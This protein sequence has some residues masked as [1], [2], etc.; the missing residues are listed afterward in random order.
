MR[1][2]VDDIIMTGQ[3][4]RN[5]EIEEKLSYRVWISKLGTDAI[6]LEHGS[7]KIK[8]WIGVSQWKYILNILTKTGMLGCKLSDNLETG[9]KNED[10]GKLVDKN[11][12]QRL[13]KTN[14]SAS[15]QTLYCICN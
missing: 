9:K 15:H 3:F 10:I 12:Y 4:G 13:V 8:N 1:V 14:L 6:L 11:R 2:Y 5:I 7:Y